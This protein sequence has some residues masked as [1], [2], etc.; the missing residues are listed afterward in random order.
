MEELAAK[1]AGPLARIRTQEESGNLLESYRSMFENRDEIITVTQDAQVRFA[2][3]AA[4][5]MFGYG[6]E[7]LLSIPTAMLVHPEDRE[8]VV[9][10][11]LA[12]QSGR[13]APDRETF[14]LFAK[15][16]T[17][18]HVEMR[19]GDT[20]WEGR[21]A[22]LSFIVD[23]T[24]RMQ[25]EKALREGG[26]I[27]RAVFE[28]AAQGIAIRNLRGRIV[29]A[30][31]KMCSMLGYGP[32]EIRGMRVSDFTM[33]EDWEHE[34]QLV[35][36]LKEGRIESFRIE[37]RFFRRDASVFWGDTTV[38]GLRDDRGRLRAC[39]SMTINISDLKRAQ[40]DVRA[41]NQEMMKVQEEERRSI[42]R[43]LHDHVAQDLSS[44][45]IACETLFDG[46][47]SVP[48][49]VRGRLDEMKAVLQTSIHSVR[50]L[51]YGLRPPEL[52][53]WGLAKTLHEYCRELSERSGL[54]IDF[55]SAG[56]GNLTLSPDAQINLF[57]IVQEALRNVRKH[58]KA[59]RAK[60]RLVGSFPK[61]ILRIEDDGSGFD[62]E[63][64][65]ADSV[66][67][68]RMGLRSMS[69]R[70]GLLGGTLTIRSSAGRGTRLR[71]E[72]PFA[73]K[74]Q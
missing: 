43:D 20:E 36:Q 39:V 58:A 70:A 44:L 48:E 55:S 34:R 73:E 6:H 7:E 23:V 54:A 41:L 26:E 50:S 69:E 22:V 18:R 59:K 5:R 1:I 15:D 10:N 65:L 52:D 67:G 51:A 46:E 28:N 13:P 61:I 45:G 71:A 19:R 2:T 56:F 62:V 14:R 47:A 32:D 64:T 9:R 27:F 24:E 60:V 74:R 53:R 37:K 17:I 38:S 63:R 25:A 40:Q 72:I 16:G 31:E 35:R 30:N 33:A 68:K 66:A 42:A 11:H 49:A 4:S 57:R 21:P 3:P 8:R 12:R 29:E